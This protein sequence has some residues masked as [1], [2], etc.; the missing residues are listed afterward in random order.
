[1]VDTYVTCGKRKEREISEK[2][3]KKKKKYGKLGFGGAERRKG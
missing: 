1:M 2:E 3:E